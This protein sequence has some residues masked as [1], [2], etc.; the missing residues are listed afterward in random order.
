LADQAISR[1]TDAL[2]QAIAP[3]IRYVTNSAYARRAGQ[4]GVADF[5]FGNPHDLPLPGLVEALQRWS[6]PQD[7]DWFAYKQNEV[8]SQE[9]V[10]ASLRAWRGLPFQPGD[11]ALTTGGFGAIAVAFRAVTD[12]GDEV[13]YSLPPWFCY[14]M[15]AIDNGLVPV[16]V[17]HDATTF[18]LDLRAIEAALTPRTRVVIVNSPCN[19]TGK[20]YPPETLA[21][22]AHLLE[23]AS[24][25][26]GRT[27][28]L[29]SDEAYSR[30]VFDGRPF[31]SPTEYYPNTLLAYSYGKVL[32]APGQRI[33]FLALPPTMPE[34]DR[35][36]QNIYIAQIAAGWAFPNALLQHA[37]G[38]LDTL[39]IDVAHL[40]RKRDRLVAA[41]R[42]MGY[43]LHVPE[44]TFYLLPKSPW[45][46]DIAFAELLGEH[47]I[48]VLPGTVAEIPTYFRVS[49]SANDEMIEQA[50]PGFAAAFKYARTV[51]PSPTQ[52]IEYKFDLGA[53][54]SSKRAKQ[55]NERDPS[56][57]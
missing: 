50:L 13:I 51:Q 33:G 34:R 57:E 5:A 40:E 45:T 39:S 55:A 25:R 42:A 20:V 11:I 26:N 41:L 23:E 22:L 27:I 19:P 3:L 16:K 38:E 47:D 36:R 6:V 17:R 49:L 14:E 21:D 56:V 52:A 35:V 12:P 46:D 48:L 7:K 15:L 8:R 44:G 43:E 31:H 4:P 9:I 1:R 28:Y 53:D 18:D 24:R 29:L 10:A 54:E 30:L 37:L 2:A 32:L